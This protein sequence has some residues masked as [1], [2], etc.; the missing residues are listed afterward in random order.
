M[1]NS[2]PHMALCFI[3]IF[4]SCGGIKN[5]NALSEIIV[6]PDVSID[7]RKPRGPADKKHCVVLEYK[8][9][10]EVFPISSSPCFHP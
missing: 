8:F 7:P 2:Q 3:I 5:C 9:E 1:Q 6:A 4:F 10:A